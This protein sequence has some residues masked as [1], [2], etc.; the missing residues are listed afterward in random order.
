M[1]KLVVKKPVLVVAAGEEGVDQ[2]HSPVVEG[3]DHAPSPILTRTMWF[4]AVGSRRMVLVE[5]FLL[6]LLLTIL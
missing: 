2:T 5:V 1:Q 6:T 3:A 4:L